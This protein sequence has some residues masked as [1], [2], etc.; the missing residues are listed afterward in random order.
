[1]RIGNKL[2]VPVNKALSILLLIFILYGCIS[3]LPAQAFEKG[4]GNF[5]KQRSYSEHFSDIAESDWF[6]SDVKTAYESGIIDG[7]SYNQFDPAGML[8]IAEVIKIAACIHKIFKTGDSN[9]APTS[10]WYRVYAD[11]AKDNNIIGSEFTDYNEPAKRYETAE[12]LSKVL[13]KE[14]FAVMN[15]LAD[16]DIPDVNLS[17]SYG[18]DV[19]LLY[20]AGIL[21]GSD[22]Y[23]VFNS[24]SVIL[25]SEISAIITRLTNPDKRLVF[26]PT[27]V[28]TYN[29][30]DFLSSDG[31]QLTFDYNDSFFTEPGNIM[32]GNLAKASIA[33]SAAALGN[34]ESGSDK[35][36]TMAF[37]SMGYKI[38]TQQNYDKDV[39]DDKSDF[40]AYTIA[41][42]NTVINKKNVTIYSIVIRGSLET[43]EWYSNF[44]IGEEASETHKGFT[45]AADDIYDSL[46]KQIKTGKENTVIWITGHSRGASISNIIAVKLNQ[47]RQYAEKSNIYTYTFGCPAVTKDPYMFDNIFNFINPGD[48]LAHI[49]FTLWGYSRNG[50]DILL[51]A[52]NETLTEMKKNFRKITNGIPYLGGYDIKEFSSLVTA[53]CPAKEDFYKSENGGLS[54]YDLFVSI[55]SLGNGDVSV[56]QTASILY[57]YKY[58][59]E[60]IRVALYLIENLIPIY[61]AHIYD[62]YLA[63]IEAVY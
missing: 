14:A 7:R 31:K 9:F 49:P 35:N 6:Y 54:P 55:I 39:T 56:F 28:I 4:F 62:M 10:E 46:V 29:Y 57:N 15:S 30:H 40:A 52:D 50:V 2:R 38:L 48:I 44:D 3:V 18:S 1:M 36:I 17:D 11:Y 37:K 58:D 59:P 8:T 42:K 23:G 51:P 33:L 43:S 41:S 25:R 12:I 47:N 19:Y 24:D 63:W 16:G 20:G 45:N 53:W 22:V 61:H 60:G 26:S 27:K 34:T 5:V 21:T 32:S 13:P